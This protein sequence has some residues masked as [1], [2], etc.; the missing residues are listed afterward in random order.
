MMAHTSDKPPRWQL[1]GD[2]EGPLNI[3]LARRAPFTHYSSCPE[4]NQYYVTDKDDIAV[5]YTRTAEDAIGLAEKLNYRAAM[6]LMA[7]P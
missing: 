7:Q 6:A 3:G 1:I 4:R 5:Y 2:R